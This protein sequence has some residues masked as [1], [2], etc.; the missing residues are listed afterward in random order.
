MRNEARRVEESNA[1][2]RKL[3]EIIIMVLVVRITQDN[4]HRAVVVRA[5]FIALSLLHDNVQH[6]GVRLTE[7]LVVGVGELQSQPV[8][9]RRQHELRRRLPLSVVQMRCVKRDRL[10]SLHERRAVHEQVV[11]A[12][13]LLQTISCEERLSA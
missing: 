8:P 5:L 1:Q 12:A 4:L 2:R 7:A 9:P 6:L 11:V 10:A 3:L 13:A